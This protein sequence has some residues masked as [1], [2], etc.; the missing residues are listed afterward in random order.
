MSE[1]AQL[2]VVT[3]IAPTD[4]DSVYRRYSGNVATIGLRI[5]GRPS[6]IDDFVQD[7]FVEVHLGLDRVREPRAIRSWVNRLAVRI[8]VRKLRR[9]RVLRLVGLEQ[10]VSYLDIADPGASPEQRALLSATFRVLD[11]VP[12]QARVAWILRHLEGRTLPDVAETTGRSLASVKRDIS[13]AQSLL[14]RRLADDRP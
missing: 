9:R 10:D 2:A 6:E 14:D 7:V 5:L 12:A 8:A 3:E 11:E 1:E 13:K 4:F